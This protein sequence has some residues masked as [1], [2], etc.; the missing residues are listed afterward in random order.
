MVRTDKLRGLMAEKKISG[1]AMARELGVSP[2]A[3]YKKMSKGRFALDDAEIMTR[4]LDIE[5]PVDI[6]FAENV[7]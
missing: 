3:F 6:F 5:N 7:T 1:V 4:V 2:Q